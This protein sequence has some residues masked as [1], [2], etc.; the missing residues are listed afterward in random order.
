MTETAP[1]QAIILA[2]RESSGKKQLLLV[3]ENPAGKWDLFK[4]PA[5]GE[6]DM[7]HIELLLSRFFSRV[8]VKESAPVPDEEWKDAENAF[9]QSC[10][11]VCE[12]ASDTRAIDTKLVWF[13]SGKD[14]VSYV[15]TDEAQ[16][17]L[18][19]PFVRS[20]LD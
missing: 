12:I 19:L 16:A 3:R 2:F 4:S 13:V 10:V 9:R 5:R 15:L 14:T 1:D 7:V 20:R 6:M 11:F 8:S 17:A 18:S